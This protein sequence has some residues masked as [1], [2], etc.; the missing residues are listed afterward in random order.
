MDEQIRTILADHAHLPVDMASL[1]DEDDLYQAGMTSTPASTSCSPSRTSSKS[2]SRDDA[3]EEHLR[4]SRCD[5]E[6][7]RR[8]D[9]SLGQAEIVL[10]AAGTR[11]DNLT[12]RSGRSWR[13]KS[14]VSAPSRP[15]WRPCAERGAQRCVSI[16][17]LSSSPVECDSM[18]PHPFAILAGV[19]VARTHSTAEQGIR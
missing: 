10:T 5:P 7:S 1:R 4:V 11:V 12:R 17:A 16:C 6:G 8:T 3:P 19:L 9:R 2:R 18:T 13:G 15:R 14:P